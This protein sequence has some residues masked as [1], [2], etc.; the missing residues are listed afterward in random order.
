MG[1]GEI[2]NVRPGW[3]IIPS[4]GRA[5]GAK[6]C[7]FGLFVASECC[8]APIKSIGSYLAECSACG[9]EF[10]NSAVPGTYDIEMEPF[11]IYWGRFNWEDSD[12]KIRFW[13]EWYF[14]HDTDVGLYFD[15]MTAAEKTAEIDRLLP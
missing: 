6:Q 11:Y 12:K 15:G 8:E 3:V 1:Y 4:D 9:A 14:A 7:D 10:H 2:V 5:Y 13:I